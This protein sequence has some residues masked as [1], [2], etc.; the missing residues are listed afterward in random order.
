MYIPMFLVQPSAFSL[1][2]LKILPYPP[3]QEIY[4]EEHLYKRDYEVVRF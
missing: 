1:Q 3:F 2:P 4:I